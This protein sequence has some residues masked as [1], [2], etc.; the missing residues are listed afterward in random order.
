MLK[1]FLLI[2]SILL[3]LITSSCNF[4]S[5]PFLSKSPT[6]RP[7]ILPETPYTSLLPESSG[8]VT[9]D[10]WVFYW[11]L[12]GSDLES[13]FGCATDDLKEMLEVSLPEG[14]K[15]VIQTGG[16]NK[17]QNDSVKSEKLQRFVYDYR[18]FHLVDEKP[19]NNMGQ[20]D[21]LYD[22]LLFAKENYPGKKTFLNIWNH[23]GGSLAGAAF[24][25]VFAMDS[26][27]LIEMQDAISGSMGYQLESPPID[28]IGFDACLMATVDLAYS[29]YGLSNYLLASQEVEPGDGWDY[30]ALFTELAKDPY[31]SPFEL[32]VAICDTYIDY[33]AQK[34]SS[35]NLTL[36]LTDLTKAS[37]LF[38]A[39]DMLGCALIENAMYDQQYITNFVKVCSSITTYGPN[40]SDLGYTNMA[41]LG[42]LAINLEEFLP[43]YSLKLQQA[44]EECVVYRV[45]GDYSINSSGLSF[46]CPYD[47]DQVNLADYS[48]MIGIKGM[49][50]LFDYLFTGYPNDEAIEY[51]LLNGFYQPTEVTS[52]L[53]ILDKEWEDMDVYLNQDSYLSM[54]L[55]SD[56]KTILSS[57]NYKLYR[58]NPEFGY[59]EYLG[60]SG[61]IY[62]YWDYG[63]FYALFNGTWGYIDGSLCNM[64]L[65]YENDHYKV[66]T[67]PIYLNGEGSYLTVLYDP[68]LQTYHLGEIQES[69]YESGASN[70]NVRYLTPGDIVEPIVYMMHS[71]DAY[72]KMMNLAGEAIRVTANTSFY[73][74]TLKDGE[75]MLRFVIGDVQNNYSHSK[76]FVI[77]KVGALYYVG[78]EQEDLG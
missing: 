26:L 46:Y 24:D 9:E 70:K 67:V 68:L 36:S 25:E 40:S 52:L 38:E 31:M 16:A 30:K 73:M 75:Y 66:Y 71:D 28:I 15:V 53:T 39:Y 32:S 56:A 3:L 22:F 8:K 42:Q 23:G 48:Q 7:S 37:P 13:K 41:D 51:I 34:E 77:N 57:V 11:Y 43:F 78:L 2:I 21:T 20:A 4:P 6:P 1:R 45:Y 12:C 76:A 58:R 17:W 55:D 27:N 5:L 35:K 54:M 64:G 33:Y 62:S 19:L 50:H 44:L 61:D 60:E 47:N 69:L 74:D 18:G 63:L 49:S 65:L 72:S 10:E 14:I 29:F 59:L